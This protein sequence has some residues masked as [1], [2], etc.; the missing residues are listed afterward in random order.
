MKKR[1]YIRK[2]EKIITIVVN[3]KIK[4]YRYKFYMKFYTVVVMIYRSVGFVKG[5]LNN[6]ELN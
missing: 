4:I 5:Y 2:L 3:V 6:L 1:D